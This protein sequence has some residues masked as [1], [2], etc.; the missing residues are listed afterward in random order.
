MNKKGFAISVILYSMVFLLVSVFYM[1]LGI[2]KTRYNTSNGLRNVVEEELNESNVLHDIITILGDTTGIDYVEKYNVT[3]GAPI[4][5]PDGSGNQE[6]YYFTSNN[7]D[8]LASKNSNVVFGEFCWQIVRTTTTGG[9]KLIYNG[10]KTSDNKCPNDNNKRPLSVGATGTI[11][12]QNTN[13]SGS[14]I[15]G[16]GFQIYDDNGSYKFRLLHTNSYSWSDSTYNNIIG[17]YACGTISS[18]TGASKTCDYIYYVGEYQ[19]NLE[20]S[21][22]RYEITVN[23]YFSQIGSS[24]YNSSSV[25][26]SF[27]GYMF[28]DTYNVNYRAIADT[29][30][31]IFGNSVTYQNGTYTIDT[32]SDTTKYHHVTNWSSNY[33]S[34]NS[35]HYTCF[36]GDSNTC[37]SSVYYVNQTT[38]DG[39][40]YIELKNGDKVADAIN[41]MYN[42]TNSN[43]SEINKY[44]SAIKSYID[45]W[46]EDNLAHVANYL[47]ENEVY[48]NDRTIKTLGGFSP[49]GNSVT[50]YELKNTYFDKPT[51]ANASLAC[52]NL[53]DRFSSSST[54]A[55]LKYPI[56]L[57][58]EAERALM[59][60]NYAKTGVSYR[61]GTAYGFDNKSV[62]YIV[63]TSGQ[64]IGSYGINE[65]YA[66]RPV[67]TL[68]GD[69]EVTGKGTYNNPY[70]V[71]TSK[72]EEI[73]MRSITI[74]AKNQQINR[75]SSI[76]SAA[77]QVNVTATYEGER[78]LRP[79]DHLQSITL[80]PSTT[81]VTSD[82][83]I[84]P[85]N[86]LILD[87]D[88]NN[89]TSLY[90]IEYKPGILVVNNVTITGD[91][92]TIEYYLGNG[93]EQEGV[94]KIGTTSCTFGS[95]CALS[96]F[97]S[98]N[99]VFPYSASDTTNRGWSF[100]GWTN[101]ISGTNRVYV[102]GDSINPSTYSSVVKIYAIGVK[103]YRFSTGIEPKSYSTKQQFWNPRSTQ[104]A[105]RTSISIP[106]ATDLSSSSNGGWTFLGYI[107]G[108]STAT[109]ATVHF[110][111]SIAG[112]TYNPI[113]DTGSTG[114]MRS[115]YQRTLTVSY[116]A[117]SGTGT[118]SDT[119]LT[120][121]YNSGYG[122]ADGT[123]NNGSTLGTN[124]ITLRNN[125]FT[126]TNYIFSKW[127]DGST[128]G[129]QYAA[130]G[131]YTGL[132]STIKSTTLSTTM[133][134]IWLKDSYTIT[135]NYH[136]N[137]AYDDDQYLN[138]GYTINWARNTVIEAKF[139]YATTGVR[140]LIIGTYG[141]TNSKNLNIEINTANKLRL[142]MG[143]GS[144]DQAS[145][146][147][148]PTNKV[149]SMKFAYNAGTKVYTLTATADGMTDISITGTYTMS[150]TAPYTL[151]TNR[152]HRGT[153]TFKKITISSLVIKDK[154]ATNS[155]LSDLPSMSKSG[156]TYKGWYTAETGGTKITSSKTVTAD[157]TY[158]AQW[159]TYTKKT[160]N[161][162]TGTW[163][164]SPTITASTTCTPRTKAQANSGNYSTYTTCREMGQGEAL[165]ECNQ[166][167]CYQKNVYNRTGCSTYSSTAASTQ[168]GLTSC[169]ASTSSTQKITCTEE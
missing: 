94:T 84:I 20:A 167:Q 16:T 108:T 18:I 100:Y 10:V 162:T 70:V 19:N 37:E 61:I 35:S 67:I 125:G 50:N 135:F 160:F 165:A 109:S 56:G 150:G 69:V 133:Y 164:T 31:F 166:T 62:S 128:S 77:T 157:A 51:K 14:K 64:S 24:P 63:N 148:L 52:P 126:R 9:I 83:K 46:Y 112:T 117:N 141:E 30:D 153:G 45:S 118:T 11:F 71:N 163:S 82:G 12:N 72:G 98:L 44:N 48:C 76:S 86:A 127:A 122:S 152:D 101:S 102:D 53:T 129:T 43:T 13:M 49:T 111:S 47:D 8:N 81:E 6:I 36:K 58:S 79:G 39:A 99:Q 154:R 139:K 161:C 130:G 3:N 65:A 96:T 74:T 107:G 91:P 17:K 145:S 80:T 42:N 87:E 25:V 156:T 142:Y 5:T 144:V 29:S 104:E 28:N 124:S 60:P 54:I 2:V 110:D 34:I 4:D 33:N 159:K 131:T 137:Q 106:A 7:T 78:R 143:S 75:G 57:L 73:D 136:E 149:I 105:Y 147:V 103:N 66:I 55:K 26:P 23:D 151:W 93:E 40:Y 116:N 169:S 88:G 22:I 41:K 119:T 38:V 92:Y 113:I 155:A 1:L 95:D 132:G 21:T 120:Q 123:T 158:H 114:T 138:T 115:K 85:S 89:V 27:V 90:V 146:V 168:T 140:H 15:Y 59:Q 32:N 68:K 97:E 121:Y 134:A